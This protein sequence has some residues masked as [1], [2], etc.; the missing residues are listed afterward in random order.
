MGKPGYKID[1][2][3]LIVR[4]SGGAVTGSARQVF[5]GT[6]DKLLNGEWL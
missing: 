6:D 2:L 3:Y 4:I 5:G 1:E